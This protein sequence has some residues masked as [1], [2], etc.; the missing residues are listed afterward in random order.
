VN[1]KVEGFFETCAARGLTGTQGV[2]IPRSNTD[3]LMLRA[4]VVDAVAAGQFRVIPIATIDDGIAL[5]TGREAGARGADGRYPEDT[6]NGLVEARLAGF[7]EA[8]RDYV[9]RREEAP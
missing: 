5:L 7:A 3:H 1:E 4:E 6:V 9:R 2:L 8:R